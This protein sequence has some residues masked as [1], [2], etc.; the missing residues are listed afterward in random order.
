MSTIE[1]NITELTIQ[2]L[3]ELIENK[4]RESATIEYKSQMP[5]PEQVCGA[6]SSLANT[7]GGD[8]YIGISEESGE[9]TELVGINCEDVDKLELQIN[10]WLQTGIE[11]RLARYD[12]TNFQLEE[13]KHIILIRAYRSWSRPHRVKE[14][15]H[16]YSR[17]SNGKFPMDVHEIRNMFLGTTEFSKMYSDFKEER[18]PHH[19]SQFA[20]QPF[21]LLHYV[22]LSSFEKHFNL[23]LSLISRLN[24]IPLAGAGVNPRINLD[25]I[26]SES[27]YTNVNSKMQIFRNGIIEQ[28]TTR[29]IT[30]NIIAAA[31]IERLLIENIQHQMFNY[32]KM[33]ISEPFYVICSFYLQ[34]EVLEILLPYEDTGYAYSDNK[35]VLP[36]ILIDPNNVETE[37]PKLSVGRMLKPMLDTLWNAFGLPE[38]KLEV[39]E[40]YRP[41]H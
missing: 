37:T 11:P 18:V 17:K 12:I 35:L 41:R 32:E 19:A 6:I 31:Q 2:D 24:L 16:F 30:N 27:R 14:N 33:G 25:G 5:R 29:L 3:N 7:F 8:F 40:S 23:D 20:D 36:E 39:E 34:S 9:P 13:N 1:K 4:V 28:A 10:G 21:C 15:R 22:P 38:A 26:F